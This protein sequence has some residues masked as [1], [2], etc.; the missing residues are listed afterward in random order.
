MARINLTDL[1]VEFE[2]PAEEQK[3]AAGAAFY[4]SNTKQISL[5]LHN[6]HDSRLEDTSIYSSNHANGFNI[7]LGDGSVR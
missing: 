6:D 1:P 3:S 5:A 2:L 7:L 4:H